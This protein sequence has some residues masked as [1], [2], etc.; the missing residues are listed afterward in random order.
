M[1]NSY[2][3]IVRNTKKSL[4]KNNSKY[5]DFTWASRSIADEFSESTNLN[6]RHDLSSNS[7]SVVEES[8][9]ANVTLIETSSKQ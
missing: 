9:F 1:L 3:Q 2:N 6:A 4:S 8:Q 7:I 5:N